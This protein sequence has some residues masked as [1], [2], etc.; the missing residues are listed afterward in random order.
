MS[1]ELIRSKSRKTD[2]MPKSDRWNFTPEEFRE[3]LVNLYG[4]TTD[5]ELAHLAAPDFNV[6]HLT[7]YRWLTGDRQ[8]SGT[9]AAVAHHLTKPPVAGKTLMIF[10]AV[11]EL[12][13]GKTGGSSRSEPPENEAGAP[14]TDYE[15]GYCF[16]APDQVITRGYA[17]YETHESVR[18]G[19]RPSM[20][21]LWSENGGR[22]VVQFHG[23]TKFMIVAI[24][25]D[26]FNDLVE[27]AAPGIKPE[28]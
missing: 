24:K 4:P 21:A 26:D 17:D 6:K 8:I 12:P 15:K 9:P 1:F 25:F 18:I 3:I 11:D 27:T 2:A 10:E 22:T 16:I 5:W 14:K 23:T 20:V 19:F 28:Q 13:S 7:V